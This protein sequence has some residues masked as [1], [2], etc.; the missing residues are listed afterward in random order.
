[1]GMGIGSVQRG[2]ADP[3]V[4]GADQGQDLRESKLWWRRRR[5]KTAGKVPRA[6][7]TCVCLVY[8]A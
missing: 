4:P 2:G 7:M 5:R 6:S 1:M 3:Q 8:R